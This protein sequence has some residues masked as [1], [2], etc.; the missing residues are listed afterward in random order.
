MSAVA[1]RALALASRCKWREASGSW[2]GGSG[3]AWRSSRGSRCTGPAWRRSPRLPRE[4]RHVKP[5][6]GARVAGVLQRGG[7][8]RQR[9]GHA[10]GPG[11]RHRHAQRAPLHAAPAHGAGHRGL[12]APLRLLLQ[13]GGGDRCRGGGAAG[14][15]RVDPRWSTGGGA[16]PLHGRP[17]GRLS[18]KTLPERRRSAFIMLYILYSIYTS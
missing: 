6:R 3:R 12:R 11:A 2:R 4:T 18:R 16:G 10:G 13:H 7:L 9:P 5:S 15:D 8:P 17:A 1:S 14:G